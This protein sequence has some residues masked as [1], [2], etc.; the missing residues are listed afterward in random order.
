MSDP[1]LPATLA[2]TRVL[3]AIHAAAFERREAW[4]AD[5][6]SLQLA[7]PGVF[8]LLDQRGGMLL[9][10]VTADEAEILTL[11]VEPW[12]RRQGIAS[13]LLRAALTEARVR[14]ARAMLLEVS[15]NN[16]AARA[17]YARAGFVE[18]GRRPRYYA[19]GSDA[20]ILRTEL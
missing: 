7:L 20:L 5:A 18:T 3:A 16:A 11:A 12:Q 15:V 1:P 2:H 14:G 8:G 6:I 4:G 9:A 13:A 17:L 19:D 10:R